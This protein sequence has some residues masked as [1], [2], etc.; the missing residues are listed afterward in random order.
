MD[1]HAH[2]L[3]TSAACVEWCVYSIMPFSS[4]SILAPFKER[5]PSLD[6][7]GRVICDRYF[8][9]PFHLEPLPPGSGVSRLPHIARD[10]RGARCCTMAAWKFYFI[11]FVVFLSAP[12]CDAV[13]KPGTPE[14]ATVAH[15]CFS[16]FRPQQL[17]LPD[18]RS[19]VLIISVFVGPKYCR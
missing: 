12:W 3:P 4:H 11:F 8:L 5:D 16:H 17:R 14:K 15:S 19:G 13:H 6:D 9:I 18:P 7:T 2:T 1:R 10:H